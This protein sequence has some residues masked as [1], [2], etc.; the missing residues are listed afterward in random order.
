MESKD[1]TKNRLRSVAA[2]LYDI[3]AERDNDTPN[4]WR[5]MVSWKVQEFFM[6]TGKFPKKILAGKDTFIKI[7]KDI[8]DASGGQVEPDL[9]SDTFMYQGIEVERYDKE[10]RAIYC[11]W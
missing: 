4:T 6:R 2:M 7:L 10:D 1:V 5:G 3:A 11:L 8:Q 9:K